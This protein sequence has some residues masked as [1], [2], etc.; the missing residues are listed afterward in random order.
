MTCMIA[1]MS[2]V[3]HVILSINSVRCLGILYMDASI[4]NGPLIYCLKM[5]EYLQ[6]FYKFGKPYLNIS[7]LYFFIQIQRTTL[8]K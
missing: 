3:K 2:V 4:T 1:Q 8:K 5:P 7:K 6:G